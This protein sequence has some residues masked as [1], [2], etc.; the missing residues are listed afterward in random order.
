MLTHKRIRGYA[1]PF[2]SQ[3]EGIAV[4][5]QTKAPMPSTSKGWD[6]F[7]SYCELYASLSDSMSAI[8]ALHVQACNIYLAR[9]QIALGQ[10]TIQTLIAEYRTN[11]DSLTLDCPGRHLLVWPTFIVAM[12]CKTSDLQ[13]YFMSALLAQ[14]QYL[15]FANVLKALDYLAVFWANQENDDWTKFCT[16][17]DVFIF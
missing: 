6:E 4:L 12:E 10:S 3:E 2:L 11:L 8:Y 17:F 13:E 15:G 7:R 14:Y 1:A 5:C 16:H 9:A